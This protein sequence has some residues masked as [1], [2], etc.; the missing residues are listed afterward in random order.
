LEQNQTQNQN[1]LK[2]VEMLRE[3][4]GSFDALISNEGVKSV[5]GCNLTTIVSTYLKHAIEEL[6]K[7]D[8]GT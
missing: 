5:V 1:Q 7:Q 2:V 6:E 8:A 3:A 4:A